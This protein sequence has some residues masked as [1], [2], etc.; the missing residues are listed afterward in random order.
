MN[1]FIGS[2]EL[3]YTIFQVTAQKYLGIIHFSRIILSYEYIFGQ[4]PEKF[5]III[6]NAMSENVYNQNEHE[7]SFC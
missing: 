6:L 5:F 2:L 3:I 4:I 7:T 1:F